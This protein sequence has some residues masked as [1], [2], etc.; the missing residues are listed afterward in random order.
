MRPINVLEIAATVNGRP[1]A[2]LDSALASGFAFDHREVAPG[3]LF[4]CI[5]GSRFDGNDFAAQAIA[6]GAA[7]CLASRPIP[8]PHILV[9]D[10]VRAISLLGS[11]YRKRVSGDV[12]GVTGSYGKTSVKEFLA[13][14]LR[15]LGAIAKTEGNRN[16]ELTAP[17]LFAQLNGTEAVVVV[18]MAMRGKGQIGELC[19]IARPTAGVV[20][21]VGHAHLESLGSRL[22]IAKA[23]RELLEAIPNYG[24]GA[25]WA[26]D[27]FRDVL[28]KHVGCH[29]GYFGFSDSADARVESCEFVG[30]ETSV[31]TIRVDGNRV[32]L[33]VPASGKHMALN[34]AAALLVASRLGVPLE[35]AAQ[36]LASAQLP[37][38]RMQ[39]LQRGGVTIVLDAYNAAP[40]SVAALLETLAGVPCEGKRRMV[41]GDMLELGRAGAE[42]HGLVGAQI[43]AAGVTSALFYGP[44]SI[45]HALPAYSSA[46]AGCEAR[47]ASN[48]D[49]VAAFLDSASPGDVVL[50]KGSR[51][52]ALERALELRPQGALT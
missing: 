28:A 48:I 30:W 19:R 17:L 1:Y 16:T 5:R 33:E 36:S 6:R 50:V 8:A 29:L 20:T 27:E 34:A 39:V 23:K 26:E 7:A 31:A 24:H 9:P 11:E 45:Q 49:E 12:V 52:M 47:S 25:I 37:A 40:G 41:L 46:C 21:N 10:V 13:A 44:N 35:E 15:P 14:A 3:D 51:A 43:A 42:L 22:E 4:I 2:I 32:E 38:M 18:E